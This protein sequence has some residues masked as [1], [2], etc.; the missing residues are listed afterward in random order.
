[1]TSIAFHRHLL[2]AAESYL[3]RPSASNRKVLKCSEEK[4]IV[5]SHR[6]TIWQYIVN[7]L[8]I[9]HSQSRLNLVS[10]LFSLV[11]LQG[12]ACDFE[13]VNPATARQMS[14]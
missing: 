3:Q 8:R 10:Q 9:I 12:M 11:V 7:G 4:I 5:E 1:M 13:P 14:S 2:S 6:I